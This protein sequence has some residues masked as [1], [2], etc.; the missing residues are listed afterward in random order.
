MCASRCYFHTKDVD[1]GC[2]TLD[3]GMYVEFDQS[4]HASHCDW[5]LIEGKLGYD[6]NIDDNMLVDFSSFQCVIFT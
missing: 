1:D 3:C 4:R 6:R 2:V 5:N